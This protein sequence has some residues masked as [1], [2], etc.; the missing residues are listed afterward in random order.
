MEP[1]LHPS[2]PPY[3]FEVP[4]NHHGG[5]VPALHPRHVFCGWWDKGQGAALARLCR[6]VSWMPCLALTSSAGYVHEPTHT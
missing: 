6:I 4:P 5:D 1:R 2:F 3:P